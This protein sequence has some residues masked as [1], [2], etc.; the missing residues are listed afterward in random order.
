ML[1]FLVFVTSRGYITAIYGPYGAAGDAYD[2]RILQDVWFDSSDE[3]KAFVAQFPDGWQ[4]MYDRGGRSRPEYD[5]RKAEKKL[6]KA[7]EE[8]K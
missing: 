6:K 1:K 3:F 8:I 2:W 4:L 5:Q 7:R